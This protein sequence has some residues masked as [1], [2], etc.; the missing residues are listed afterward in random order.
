MTTR[1]NVWADGYG[2]WHAVIATDGDLTTA[3]ARALARIALKAE[4]T[5]RAGSGPGYTPTLELVPP[6]PADDA[7]NWHRY[8]RYKEAN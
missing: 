5:A 4:I 7:G 3:D 1:I 6:S 8:W 2:T